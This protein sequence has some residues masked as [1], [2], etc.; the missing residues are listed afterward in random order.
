MSHYF[1]TIDKW[2]N[3]IATSIKSIDLT[4]KSYQSGQ[5]LWNRV[6]GYVT[7]MTNF[8]GGSD[9]NV[10][11]T[12]QMIQGR[13]LLLAIPPN[14]SQAQLQIL[15]QLQAWAAQMNVTVIIQV[16]K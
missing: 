5:A 7:E 11:I 9:P 6:A 8:T 16:V 1:P 4:A 3:G 12:Q 2:S 14:A 10:V 15:Q 13:E